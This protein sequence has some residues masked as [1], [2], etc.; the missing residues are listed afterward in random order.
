[1]QHK[2]VQKYTVSL[3]FISVI[4]MKVDETDALP[5]FVADLVLISSTSFI[6]Q[7]ITQH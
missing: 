2:N 5:V 6:S 3:S 1:M 7:H 4:C